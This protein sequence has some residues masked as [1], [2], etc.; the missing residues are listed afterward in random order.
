MN[1]NVEADTLGRYEATYAQKRHVFLHSFYDTTLYVDADTV[2]V[3]PI[4]DQVWDF[5]TNAVKIHRIPWIPY[6]RDKFLP[7]YEAFDHNLQARY[8]LPPESQYAP[9]GI[10]AGI[11]L[12][13]KST[14]PVLKDFF[15]SISQE[16]WRLS[17]QK[18]LAGD[19]GLLHFVCQSKGIGL[20]HL[21]RRYNFY[22]NYHNQDTLWGQS[23]EKTFEVSFAP[24]VVWK[25][26]IILH[27]NV[28]WPETIPRRAMRLAA[29]RG[30]IN[31]MDQHG[32]GSKDEFRKH[33]T[34]FDPTTATEALDTPIPVPE[35]R[36]DSSILDRTHKKLYLFRRNLTKAVTGTRKS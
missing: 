34:R 35:R 19:Q 20:V 15:G 17:H 27:Y 22:C 29:L 32:I 12:L 7:V 28:H 8:P 24:A 31:L 26:A 10:Q 11:L 5:P 1:V 21:E 33:L 36:Q 25:E 9:I 14:H 6:T 23:A 30:A 18:K 3:N 2:F 4:E 16:V 13:H